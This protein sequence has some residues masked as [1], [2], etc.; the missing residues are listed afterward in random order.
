[1]GRRLERLAEI[2]LPIRRR[3]LK[4]IEKP[5]ELLRRRHPPISSLRMACSLDWE[6]LVGAEKVT[7]C[8]NGSSATPEHTETLPGTTNMHTGKLTVRAIARI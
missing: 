1:M 5:E 4:S 2:Q 3:N 6:G 8:R 7:C